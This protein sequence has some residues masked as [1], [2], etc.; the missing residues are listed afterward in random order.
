MPRAVNYRRGVGTGPAR[1][2]GKFPFP[3]PTL[4]HLLYDEGDRYT[5]ADW[6]LVGTGTPTRA[7]VDDLDGGILRLGNSAASG[8][9]NGIRW[10]G[11]AGAA[12]DT[13]SITPGKR[14]GFKTQ[15]QLSAATTVSA[16]FG[17]TDT[18]HQNVITAGN[19]IAIQTNAGAG[20]TLLVCIAGALQTIT[21]V[22]PPPTVTNAM[23]G[24]SIIYDRQVVN[25]YINNRLFATFRGALPTA[26]MS[27]F[28][29]VRNTAAA[30]RNLDVDYFVAMKER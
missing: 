13:F 21:A 7:I 19:A 12:R 11:G 22:G 30:A 3:D 8:D 9:A 17:F 4:V 2:T 10:A 26:I 6:A 24:F 5:A 16:N 27:P 1:T 28:F 15:I 23:T 20:W 29:S 18:S 14:L 25:A